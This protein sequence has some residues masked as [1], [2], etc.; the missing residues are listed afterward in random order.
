MGATREMNVST[1]NKWLVCPTPKPHAKARLFCFPYAGGAANIYRNWQ[2]RLPASIEVCPVQI[3][4]RGNRLSEAPYKDLLLLVEAV[5]EALLPYLDKP[6]AFFGHSMGALIGFELA[7]LLRNQ[8]EPEPT[9]LF[10]SGRCAPQA[11]KMDEPTYAL[12]EGEFIEELRR[13]KG[14]P[15]EALEQP[16]LMQMMLPIIRADFEVCQT[17]EYTLRSPLT[18][19]I[20]AY[21]GLQDDEV[22]RADLEAWGQHTSANTRLRM[23]PGDHF[24]LHSSAPALLQSLARDLSVVNLNSIPAASSYLNSGA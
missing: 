8:Q 17:Y 16:E 14:T 2:Q 7:H 9:Q 5:G 12:P 15:R 4:G 20:K 13:L 24:F 19:P 11:G 1:T 10:V 18:C 23:F 6:F 3:P 22:T 21:G